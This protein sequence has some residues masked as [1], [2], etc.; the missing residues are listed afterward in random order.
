MTGGWFALA[1]SNLSFSTKLRIAFAFIVLASVPILFVHRWSVC[2]PFQCVSIYCFLIIRERWVRS[3]DQGFELVSG[4]LWGA[5][6]LTVPSGSQSEKIRS[7][8]WAECSR[9]ALVWT[10]TYVRQRCE[11]VPFETG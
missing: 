4:Q 5:S 1:V 9:R 2:V 3:L 7:T 11:M 6:W 10:T 8:T